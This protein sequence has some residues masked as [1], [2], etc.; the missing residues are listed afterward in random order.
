MLAI[1]K[2]ALKIDALIAANQ[3]THSNGFPS[4]DNNALK[5]FLLT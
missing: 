4:R 5:W 1:Q 2:D 3:W